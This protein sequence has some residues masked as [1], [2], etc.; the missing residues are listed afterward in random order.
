MA[1]GA[2][3]PDPASEH[4]MRYWD[5]ASWT[6]NV[7]DRGV[8]AVDAMRDPD[9]PAGKRLKGPLPMSLMTVLLGS[10]FLGS[11]VMGKAPISSFFAPTRLPNM[12]LAGLFFAGALLGL[13]DEGD[14]VMSLYVKERMLG[15]TEPAI[16]IMPWHPGQRSGFEGWIAS[17]LVVGQSVDARRLVE[18]WYEKAVYGPDRA[19]VDYATGLLVESGYLRYLTS[20]AHRGKLGGLVLGQT[21]QTMV[22]AADL[23]S[24]LTDDLELVAR[25]WLAFRWKEPDLYVALFNQCHEG[26][27]ARQVKTA[28]S[29][30]GMG[31]GDDF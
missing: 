21:K 12:N 30:L 28:R 9:G 10:G 26:I 16:A 5:G 31:L 17:R 3:Y 22:A 1:S 13:R 2:W 8:S 14:I 27:S 23:V 29:G 25:R 4:E 11:D 19:L 18:T 7:S 15:N 20:D 6:A 24:G